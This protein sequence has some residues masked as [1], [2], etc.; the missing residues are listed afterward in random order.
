M[1]GWVNPPTDREWFYERI[2]VK[3]LDA[4]NSAFAFG[5]LAVRRCAGRPTVRPQ[6]TAGERWV[7]LKAPMR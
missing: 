3:K 1:R 6:T 7:V 5:Q 4:V 2:Q